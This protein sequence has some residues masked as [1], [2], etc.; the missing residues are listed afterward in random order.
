MKTAILIASLAT[1]VFAAPKLQHLHVR[2]LLGSSFGIPGK[3]A[4]YDYVII[5]GGTAGL[6]LATRLA[7]QQTGSVAVI[8]AGG[9]YE[10]GNGNLSQVPATDNYYAGKAKNDWQPMIDWGYITAPQAVSSDEATWV[11]AEQY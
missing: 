9:F 6:T 8:E 7:E 2:K 3:N 4:T 1:Y 10:I 11:E 5:G